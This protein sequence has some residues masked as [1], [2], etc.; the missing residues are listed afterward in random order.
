MIRMDDKKET[1]VPALRFGEFEGNNSESTYKKHFFKDIFLFSTGKNIKQSEA[2]PEFE[3]PCIRYGELY[4]MYSEVIYEIINKTNLDKSELRFSEGNEILLPSAGED[5]L[6]IGSAS[7]LTLKNIAIGRTINVLRPTKSNVYTQNYVSYYINQKLRK[8]IS[9]LAKGSSISNVYNSDL[10]KLE[11]NL[12]TLPEQQKIANFLSSVDKKIEQLRQKVKLLKDYKTGVMQQIFSQQIR[13]KD[14]NGEAFSDWEVKTLKEVTKINQGLQIPISKRYKEKIKDSFFYI[15]NEFLKE[16]SQ[17]KYF[18]KNPSK[19]VLCNEEDILM[20][21]TG[22]TGQVVTG[23][24]GVFHNNFFKIKFNKE[25]CYKWYLYYF[26]KSF[27]TQR[28]ILKLAGSSTIPD[29]NHGDFYNIKMPFPVIKEQE[30]I[31]N[32]L[33][34]ID[35]KIQQAQTQVAQAQQFKKGLLQQLFV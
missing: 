5:P 11:I 33:S 2:S 25:N 22:N 10:K 9:T 4:Y 20:T 29:L 32:Y 27:K 16:K 18:I 21:R 35:E 31:A 7:A 14:D 3:I 1:L 26:L 8:K 12:P 15:T 6:D 30:K 13:F 24:K 23:V 17:K 19:S 28:N 34:S